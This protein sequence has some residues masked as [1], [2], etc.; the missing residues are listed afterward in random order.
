[1][2][3]RGEALVMTSNAQVL[4]EAGDIVFTNAEQED[5]D[6]A[7]AVTISLLRCVR[8]PVR[9]GQRASLQV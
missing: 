3:T 4:V 8:L 2:Q 6:V 5:A 7:E 1:M 9:P